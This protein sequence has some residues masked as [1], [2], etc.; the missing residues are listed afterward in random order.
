MIYDHEFLPTGAIP[1]E[2]HDVRVTHVCTPND[3]LRAVK[4]ASATP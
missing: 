4:P 3:G 2:A 1:Y